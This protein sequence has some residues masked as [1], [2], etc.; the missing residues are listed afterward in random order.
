MVCGL[1]WV[2]TKPSPLTNEEVS[3]PLPAVPQ[4]VYK[5]MVDLSLE[6]ENSKSGKNKLIVD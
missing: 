6:K 5:R 1:L 3:L 4:A 2:K